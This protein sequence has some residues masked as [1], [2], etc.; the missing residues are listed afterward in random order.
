MAYT[1]LAN[2]KSII[3][4]RADQPTDGTSDFDGSLDSALIEVW[5]DLTIRHPWMSLIKSPPG[6]FLTV[7]EDTAKTLTIATAGAS[8]AATLSAAPSVSILGYRIQPTGKP[9]FLRVT[10][11]TATEVGLTVDAAP[12]VLTAQAC[13]IVKDEYDLAS[14]LGMFVD[15]LWTP[16]SN[17]PVPLKPEQTVK[18]DVGTGVTT[19]WPPTS[20]ARIGPTRIRLSH[21]PTAIKR[22]EYPYSRKPADPSTGAL[23]L[24]DYLLPVYQLGALAQLYSELF[25]RRFKATFDRYELGIRRAFEYETRQ[26]VAV[27]GHA[28]G[29]A[30]AP[31]PWG[32]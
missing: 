13:S 23:A 18:E 6:V 32:E 24:D 27:L 12:E 5:R 3:L 4:F 2:L 28:A 29:G 8:V 26:R 25:D 10:A 11:H 17:L 30:V 1:T 22:V 9:Y 31:S 16:D 19:G 15:G 7:A 20:F 21:A 14:D